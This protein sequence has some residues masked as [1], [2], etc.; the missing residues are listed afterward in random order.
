MLKRLALSPGAASPSRWNLATSVGHRARRSLVGHLGRGATSCG[1]TSSPACGPAVA[2]DVPGVIEELRGT[3][4]SGESTQLGAA[5]RSVLDDLRGAAP[6]AIVLVTD[7]INTLGPSLADAAL[8]ARRKGVPLFFVG[9]GSDQPRR[10]LKLSD[11]RVDDVVFAG[12]LVAFQF[13]LTGVGYQGTKVPVVLR[14]AGPGRAAGESGRDRGGRRP[15]PGSAPAVPSQ[16][17]GAVPLHG[18]GRSPRRGARR[19]R[20]TTAWSV[21]SR[22]ARRRS[23]CYWPRRIR[24]SSS[25]SCATCWPA[26]KRSNSIPCCRTPTWSMPSR[27]RRPC[28]YSPSV[29]TSCSPTTSSFW[30]T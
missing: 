15:G 19:S 29:A 13:N 28:A 10:D 30:A 22:S 25:A 9:L 1:S 21:P 3:Q 17:S 24:A 7:G 14:R 6:A 11:L 12:D 4:P 27:T 23:A 26:T 16:R 5:V 8:T 2:A 20:E 18:R